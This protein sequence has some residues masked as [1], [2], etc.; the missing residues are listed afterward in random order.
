MLKTL[1]RC[2]RTIASQAA[3]SPFRQRSISASMSLGCAEEASADMSEETVWSGDGG[4]GRM[5]TCE[6]LVHPPFQPAEEGLL[7]D[8]VSVPALI[9]QVGTP[10]YIYSAAAI[11]EAYGRIDRAFDSY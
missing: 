6:T 8:G 4:N 3:W 10:A 1:R 5:I 11:R 7:C 2:K 9:A